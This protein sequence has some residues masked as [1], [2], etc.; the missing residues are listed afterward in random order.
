MRPK[1]GFQRTPFS[2]VLG[3]GAR[4]KPVRKRKNYRAP[5]ISGLELALLEGLQSA[6]AIG[7]ELDEDMIERLIMHQMLELAKTD[8][9]TVRHRA[10]VHFYE[11]STGKIL[12]N[13][14]KAPPTGLEAPLGAEI[15][16][17]M[18]ESR[19]EEVLAQAK[20]ESELAARDALEGFGIPRRV[21]TDIPHDRS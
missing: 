9:P 8:R 6:L 19:R 11:L 12:G 14:S 17:N 20:A 1:R 18:E 15:T 13:K 5:P 7:E 2:D 16:G 3:H 10:L 21:G 4:Q